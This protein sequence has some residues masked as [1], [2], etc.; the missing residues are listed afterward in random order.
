MAAGDDQLGRPR[1]K[2]TNVWATMKGVFARAWDHKA[3][4]FFVGSVI[5][6]F[7]FHHVRKFIGEPPHLGRVMIAAIC[8]AL[9]SR[10]CSCARPLASGSSAAGGQSNSS[11]SCSRRGGGRGC[12]GAA[13]AAWGRRRRRSRRARGGGRGRQPASP[14][15]PSSPASYPASTS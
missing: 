12:V 4:C 14:V 3:V 15:S 11:G 10:A 2:L 5:L 6:S 9:I 8:A 7:V 1:V 13:R